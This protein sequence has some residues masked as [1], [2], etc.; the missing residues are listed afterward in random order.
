M[1]IE[2]VF[3][4]WVNTLVHMEPDRHVVSVEVCREF[5]I[6][7]SERDIMRGIYVAEETMT[8]GRPL[9]WSADED[10]EVYVRYNNTV[11]TAAGV[12]PPDT[13]TSIVML[14][15]FAERFK[16]FRFAVFE[17]VR[18]ALEEL[19][20][21]NIITG[22]ISNMPHQMAPMLQR[23]DLSGLIDHAVT[24][25]DVNGAVKPAPAVFLEALRRAGVRADQALHVG[26]EHF[27]DGVGARAAG[28][29]PVI[30][31]R[32]DLF[33]ALTGYHRIRSLVELPALLDSLPQ[34]LPGH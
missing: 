8:R 33:P 21:R 15:R 19:R 25:L 7:V 30:L 5:G 9:R 27:V 26:D 20:H 13:Q 16:D 24:P 10:P 3:F 1:A 14:Q 6:D 22:L 12:R 32:Y 34:S 23:L 11:L 29:T 31:D 4:D 18:P 17:D 2:A 28:I